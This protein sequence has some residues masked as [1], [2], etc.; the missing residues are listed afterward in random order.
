MAKDIAD[1][2]VKSGQN[3]RKYYQRRLP[4]DPSKDYYYILRDT[5]NNQSIIIEYGFADSSGDDPSLIK[6]DWEELAEAVVRGVAKYLGVAY[7][8]ISGGNTYVVKP[9]DTLWSIAKKYNVSVNDLKEKNN[10]SSNSLSIGQVLL[11]PSVEDTSEEANFYIVQSGDNLYSLARRFNTTIDEIKRLNNLSTNNLSIG[12]KLIINQNYETSDYKTYQVKKGDSL[13]AIAQKFNTT[14]DELKKINGITNNILSIGQILR[15]PNSNQSENI[16]Y[17]V[18]AG[19]N[20]YQ[21]AKKFNTTVSN[22]KKNNNLTSDNLSI[23]QR[24]IISG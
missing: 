15:I 2:F 24:L 5:P 12:Q 8:P 22:I 3:V 6:E 14:V 4:S 13:Y 20:L 23:G 21:I 10:L 18:V 17:T 9:G 16:I 1:E 7:I 19:D 11:I